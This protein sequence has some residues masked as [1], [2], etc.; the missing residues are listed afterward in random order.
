MKRNNLY[1]FAGRALLALIFA[2]TACYIFAALGL[3]A[4]GVITL[5]C[6]ILGKTG[7]LTVISDL[8]P[9]PL[10]LISGG[11][12]SA[13]LGMSLGIIPICGAAYGFYGRFTKTA[14]ILRERMLNEEDQTS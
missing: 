10:L 12:T 8:A 3:F 13:G 7:M 5:P 2:G 1:I 9:V 6:V 4:F 14:A 11:I